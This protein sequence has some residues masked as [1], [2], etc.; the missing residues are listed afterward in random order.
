MPYIVCQHRKSNMILKVLL[1]LIW[2]KQKI[3]K[4]RIYRLIDGME[5]YREYCETD[6]EYEG[7]MTDEQ[8][9]LDVPLGSALDPLIF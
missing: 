4:L 6:S 2:I 7:A 9:N 8:N 5:T 3:Y 1:I